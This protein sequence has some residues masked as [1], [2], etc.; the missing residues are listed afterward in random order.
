MDNKVDLKNYDN[1]WFHPGRGF[2]IRTIWYFVNTLFFQ[3]SL[4]PFN[5]PKILLLK[6]FG[7]KVGIEVILKPGI[8]VKYPWYL[9]IGDN[10][11]IGENAWVD[12][13]SYV[14]IGRNVCISQGA[15]LCTG[16]HDWSDPAFGLVV[17]PII[18]EDGA[19]IGARASVLPGVNIATHSIITAGSVVSKNTE[20]FMIYTGNPAVKINE[21]KIR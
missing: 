5:R 19:W 1:A 14:K 17:K 21:R 9:E 20:P 12:N 8:N 18:V 16:N 10:S 6:L 13:L 11:W 2:F 4:F 3:N 7:A 15:Y